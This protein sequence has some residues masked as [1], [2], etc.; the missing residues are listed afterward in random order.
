MRYFLLLL[1][2]W[3]LAC[4]APSSSGEKT[5]GTAPRVT[6][7]PA[8]SGGLPLDKIRLPEGFRITVFAEGIKNARS[9]CLSPDG[10]LF[11][12][13]RNEGSVYALR[14]TNGDMTADLKYELASGLR[15]P[16]GVAFRNGA[17]FVAEVSRILR[18][19]DIENRL[20]NPPQPVVVY[21]KYPTDAHHGWKYIAFGPDDKLYIPVGAPCNI[22]EPENPIYCSLTRLDVDHPGAEPEIVQ[23]GIRNTVGFTWHPGNRQLWFTDNGRDMLG[24]DIP[25]C[26]LNHAVRDGQHFGYPYCHQGDLPDPKFGE[27]RPCSDFT[28]PAQNLGPHT[29]PLGLE[30]VLSSSWPEAYKNQILIAEHGSWNRSK[31]IGYRLTLVRL[32]EEG[33]CI[34]Y[35]PFADGWLQPEEQVWGRPV[36]LEWLPDGSLLVSDDYADAIYRIW[37]AGGN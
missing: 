34:S 16:N 11:V 8:Y 31:K 26:E 13:T 20:A 21:D 23:S 3:Q 2:L 33:Q 6:A 9:M 10:T 1:L 19:D 28:P 18:F 7:V 12:G 30:F 37:Y 4:K 32:G 25:A 36:D 24:D 17:L 35:E 27:K 5:T 22:C 15:M 14:D 29:A